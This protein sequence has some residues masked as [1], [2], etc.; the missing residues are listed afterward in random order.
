MNPHPCLTDHSC[1]RVPAVRHLAWIC[2]AP[3]LIKSPVGFDLSP[4][5]PDDLEARLSAWDAAPESGPDLLTEAPAGRLGHYFERLY[6]CLLEELLGWK[7]LLK[8]QPVRRGGITLGEL[9]FVVRNPVTQAVEHHEIAVKFYLGFA[10]ARDAQPLW[11][12]PNASDR[13]DLKSGRLISHQSR[14][15]EK[16]E[17]RDLLRALKIPP[18]TQARIFMPG[19]LFYPAGQPL[20]PPATVPADHLQGQWLYLDHLDRMTASGTL[21]ATL[22]GHWV[23]LVKPHWLGPWQQQEAPAPSDADDALAQV[24]ATGSPRLFAVLSK[25]PGQAPGMDLWREHTRVFVVPDAWPNP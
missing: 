7:L 12:G 15:A 24:R 14:L 22:G 21:L 20:P 10:G 18:P 17:T 8:N 6:G 4:Y 9:D 19:Y 25:V 2:R 5:L 16:P 23:P 13:L 3:Q 11:Y 1:Y